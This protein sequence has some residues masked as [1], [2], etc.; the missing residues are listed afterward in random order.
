MGRKVTKQNCGS[1]SC[2]Q[3]GGTG[4][5][6]NVV[7]ERVDIEGEPTLADRL[8]RV[9]SNFESPAPGRLALSK[10]D[11]DLADECVEFLR[12]AGE[13]KGVANV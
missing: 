11:C 2:G 10:R 6:E 4:R 5:V 1:G 13:L 12:N 8:A 9:I 3:C 7:F